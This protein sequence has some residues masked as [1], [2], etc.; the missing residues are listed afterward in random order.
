VNCKMA[1]L[2]NSMFNFSSSCCI[3]VLVSIFYVLAVVVS[4]IVVFCVLCFAS[5]FFEFV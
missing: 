4:F 2:L 3:V 5:M 1:G